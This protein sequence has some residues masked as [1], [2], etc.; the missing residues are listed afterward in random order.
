[1]SRVQRILV[2]DDE[3]GNRTLL[4]AMLASLGY[5]SDLAHNGS[6]ALERLT[7]AIDL[8]LLD[9]LMPGLDGFEVTRRIRSHAVC[10]A[11]PVIMVTALE[12]KKDRLRA[13]AAGANDFICKPIDRMEL[14]IRVASLLRM[15][16]AQDALRQSEE[17]YRELVEHSNSIILRWNRDGRVTFL[18]EFGQTFFGY[19]G[20]EAIGRHMV[21]TIVPETG[22]AGP[23][24]AQMIRDIGTY[25]ERY[26]NDQNES[27]RR[28]G[29][30]VWISWTNRPIFDP[31][32]SVV[33][34]LSVGNDH[35]D[36]K[37]AE[38]ELRKSKEELQIRVAE[39]TAE[40]QSANERL[41]IELA[42]RKR[43]EALLRESEEK[44]RLVVERA[45]E[46]I[47]VAQDGMLRFVNPKTVGLLTY[48]EEELLSKPFTD[49]VFPDDRQM[50][51]ERHVR[52]LRGEALPSRYPFRL[53]DKDG[54]VKWVEIDSAVIPWDD[55]PAALVFMTDI[56]ERMLMEE[57]LRESEEWYRTLVENSFDGLFVQK[58]PKIVFAN[59]RLCEMLGYSGNELEG[60]DHWLIYHP[61]YQ[62]ITR[63]RALA[64][65]RGKEVEPRYEVKLQRKDGTFFPGE[66]TAR[67]LKVR[68]EPGVQVW[69]RDLSKRKRSEKVQRRLATAVEQAAEAI[70]ITDVEGTIQYV[71]PAFE[72]ISGYARDEVLGRNP[73]V[74]QSGSHDQEFYKDLWDTITGGHVWT[75]SFIN[76]RKDGRSIHSDTTISP[77]KDSSGK[78][79]NFV[80]VGR[81]MTDHREL[82]KQLLHA[83]KMEAIG[84]LSGGIAHDFNNLLTVVLGFTEI[85]LMEK[86]ENDREYADLQ[87]ILHAAKSG[88]ELVQRLLT[89]SRRVEP[90]PVPLNLNKQITQVEKLL[91]RTIPKMIDIQL[92]LS[93]HL[94]EIDADPSQ[95]EL[96]LMNLAVNARDAMPDGGKLSIGTRNVSLDDEYCRLHVGA[97]PGDYVLL[98]VSDT[99]HGM[100]RNTQEHIFE[101]F[102]TTK[103]L[104]RGT[105]LGLAMVYGIVSQHHGHITC[106]S[107]VG[108]GTTFS[109]H[110]PAVKG[111]AVQEV[112]ETAV[113]P[114]FGTETLML[115]DD[116]E[117]VRELGAR[118]LDKAGY[119]VLA[120]SN[121][122]EARE[123]FE[124]ERSRVSLVVL[125]LIM[126][127]MGG[128][129]CLREL[130]KIDPQVRVLVT[131][132]YSADAPVKDCL[133]A[134]AKGFV[135]KPFRMKE[136]LRQVRRVLDEC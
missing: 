20:E 116:E 102:Y 49:F 115:V 29:E 73:R 90:Q 64:R 56:T 28:N 89:F 105:G 88:A 36:L 15:K 11:V 133:E 121:G 39:R 109:V 7:P 62:S 16:E 1:M 65:M 130:L 55:R 92:N 83:Q 120:A 106:E 22:Q 12:G 123:L 6:E 99:G 118:I 3:Q 45:L 75:G 108:S 101:P 114:A 30:R 9:V 78:I 23:N 66:I 18:N 32:G 98:A 4:E 33:E 79:V 8:V 38:E 113:M 13:V 34:I 127:E 51:Y 37:R 57:A 72:S 21:G 117:F 61:D 122:M 50:V 68:G 97:T 40:L 129:E 5:E 95:I 93:G 126:P 67:A 17:K 63:D 43:A 25:P 125:D 71:N 70:I 87:K 91:R 10:K 124:K 94:A 76:K 19:S 134:G 35:T 60:M 58:G 59:V 41:Q 69:I 52:R 135:R 77:V 131:S 74:L 96:V 42:E 103:E 136:L 53:L 84:T 26:V 44:Y 54:T 14:Q 81:D 27:M 48:T 24:L 112:D 104:G 107:Q 100:D 128:K 31:H 47:F 82:S 132:G 86:N 80:A 85:M 119:T 111:P 2:V 110:F 46:G